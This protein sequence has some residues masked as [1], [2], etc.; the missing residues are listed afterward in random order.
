MDMK[1]KYLQIFEYLLEF[2]KLRSKPV[3]DI[4]SSDQY[5]EN[6]YLADIPQ[7]D[8]FDAVTFKKY[9]DDADYWLKISKPREPK[10]PV[11]PEIDGLL[12]DWIIIDS[13]TN[14]V[15]E[16]CLNQSIIKNGET[17]QLLD[18]PEVQQVFDEY[19]QNQ[20][21]YDLDLYK[22]QVNAFQVKNDEFAHQNKIYKKFF[23][24]FNKVS[25]FGEEFELV[26]G[27]GLLYFKENDNT[28]KI[29][30]HIL[31]SKA[32]ITF[33]HSQKE[34]II[35]VSY[36]N[37][38]KIQVETD[39]IIDLDNQF[40]VANIIAAEN[41]VKTFLETEDIADNLFSNQVE[42]AI[43]FFIN[44]IHADGSL[45]DQ[46]KPEDIPKKPTIYFAPA[47][48]LR[49][50]N[51][52]SL[53]AVYE[54][55]IK[56]VNNADSALDIPSIN[57]ILDLH[58]NHDTSNLSGTTSIDD[59]T[60]Y[61]PKKFNDEQ[62]QIIGKIRSSNKVLVQ[63]PPGTGKSHT[64]ANLICHLLA[65]GQKVLVTAYTKRALEVLKKQMPED[66]QSLTVNLLSGDSTSTQ[67][68]NQSVN[69]ITEKLA[70]FTNLNS[71]KEEIEKQKLILSET[72]A[73][74]AYTINEWSKVKERSTTQQRINPN[75]E[76]T[77][78]E[79]A[80]RLENESSTFVWFKD[81][82]SEIDNIEEIFLSIQEFSKVAKQYH[83]IELK[84][85]D[86]LIPDADRLLTPDELL[87]YQGVLAMTSNAANE[88]QNGLPV[89]SQNFKELKRK[90]K[91]LF[92]LCFR[93]EKVGFFFKDRFLE[94]YHHDNLMIWTDKVIKT[95]NLLL[96]LP[97]DWLRNLQRNVVITYPNDKS[98]IILKNDA[99]TLLEYLKKGKSLNGITFKL[100][101]VLLP[102]KVSQALYLIDAVLV[103]GK[104]CNTIEA[105]QEVLTDIKIKQDLEELESIWELP[106]ANSSTSYAKRSDNF[107]QLMDAAVSLKN[108]LEEY[109][110]LKLEIEQLSDLSIDGNYSSDR[111]AELITHVN[112]C[113]S[114]EKLDKY[115]Q[116]INSAT[117]YLG[118]DNIHPLAECIIS[119]IEG[120]DLPVYE[121]LLAQ[122][123]VLSSEK[124]QYESYQ[125]IR[126][127]LCLNFP[128]LVNDIASGFF[129]NSNIP[130]IKDAIYFK[131]AFAE[132]S[133]LL[134]EDYE[135][136]LVNKLTALEQQEEKLISEIGSKKAWLS[137]L[138]RLNSDAAL[139][140][141]LR[142]WALA[143][144][145]IGKTGVGKKAIRSQREAQKQ[146]EKC[147]DSVPCWVMPLYKVV[148]TIKP[149][150]GMYDYVI[151]D[152]ASQL[153]PDAIFLLYISKN[154]IIVGDDKQ[155]SPEF[156]GVADGQM[157]PHIQRHL[158]NIPF[159]NYYGTDYSFFD[160]AKLFCNGMT[161]LREHFRCMP[162]II[163]F[164]NIWFYAPEKKGLYPLKQYS[165]NRLEPLQAVYC[166]HGYIDGTGSNIV[167]E[168]E[169]KAIA[170]KIAEL[171]KDD[172]YIGKT[173][174]VITLQGNNQADLVSSCILKKIGEI[175]YN[176]RNIVCG[177]SASFQG[178][179]RD[180]MFLSLVTAHNHNRS[181]LTGTADDRRFNVAVS[182]AKEQIWLFHSVPLSKLKTDDLRYK[183]LNHFINYNDQQKPIVSA[184]PRVR[185][186]H[187]K[188]F[189]SWF[190]IDVFNDIVT[191]NYSVIPQY[192]VANGK[193]RIDLVI[194]L[195]NGVKIAVECD[196]DIHHTAAE[197]VNDLMRQRDLERC[198]WQFFR[199][200]GSE[201][202][203]NRV[204]AL[205][206]L[207]T[208]LAKNDIKRQE[209]TVVDSSSESI[210]VPNI[211]TTKPI[212][213]EP[214]K[215]PNVLIND[216]P[217][218]QIDIFDVEP[219][220]KQSPITKDLKPIQNKVLNIKNNLPISEFLAF[221]SMQQVYKIKSNNKANAK[222]KLELE[223]DEKLSHLIKIANYSD[224]LLVAFENGKV[225]K[226]R[227]SCYQ[228]EQNRKKLKNAFNRESKLIFVEVLEKEKNIDL[229][230]VSNKNKVIVFNTDKISSVSFKTTQGIQVMHLKDGSLMTKVKRLD[231]VKLND[232]E[233]YRT[234]GLNVV[235]NYLRSGDEV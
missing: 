193:Y 216:N 81:E 226:I 31:T 208:L 105:L 147:K 121:Q 209:P 45:G 49:K 60:I 101:K 132:I 6:I 33:N 203:S 220:K 56:N 19:I 168:V 68:L 140:K 16:P 157:T 2:S 234:K 182:R 159:A 136:V 188:P 119:A 9:K 96:D 29:C 100:K 71:H 170:D 47:L 73:S 38:A 126:N 179:E 87:D 94:D 153:G 75:Y 232:P 189:D 207:W 176:K 125:N 17:I 113:E 173:F 88:L 112:Y 86:Y 127:N 199:V 62:L 186:N 82:Y 7:C 177:N 197:Y 103:L 154:I 22:N 12:K 117:D 133:K 219:T 79:I 178:D 223:D 169:A 30:R 77:L 210:E 108:D 48:L 205:E 162:E 143:Q 55:I 39:A 134:K 195:P 196:G 28:P 15:G 37:G 142:A 137:V 51:T 36:S 66:F 217:V 174:G 83:A 215:K 128:H 129:D 90:L 165:E 1:N 138:E 227:L 160:H 72:K 135:S 164:C 65:N 46:L 14:E 18:Q 171:V 59:E 67:E 192:N 191:R 91:D 144:G 93:I 10:S 200:R 52:K 102:P 167:N 118:V 224:H 42:D 99:T 180:V 175:Q 13:L 122:I 3:R 183:L 92:E 64:I 211:A 80:E 141:Y 185:G 57:D 201:Y 114:I 11:F 5:I 23:N 155:T 85:F 116:K 32:D 20:W 97:N 104:P 69:T 44:T 123:A 230:V 221:T 161:V 76:G 148:E 26:L 53:T 225:G 58:Y 145:N 152:E 124:E 110:L 115:K 61:F 222:A 107:K 212:K 202:Y 25:Q 70:S 146:M 130:R 84:T 8:S 204:K 34:T 50:R 187:P 109:K 24:I 166:Q 95:N 35:K 163:E 150:Q 78:L 198:G 54:Q 131:H 111:V 231:G 213:L 27:A 184:I 63:G 120:F 151:I 190:E 156:I 218:E 194:L 43:Q 41:K 228:T 181:A 98:L 158:Q 40:N 235:G 89:I 229:V 206:T 139:P 4:E 214:K 21:L 74:K 233:Y 106:S 149:E 172:N